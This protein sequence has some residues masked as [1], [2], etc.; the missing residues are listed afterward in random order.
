MFQ[1]EYISDALLFV[2]LDVQRRCVFLIF[3]F[4][5]CTL[6]QLVS[7]RGQNSGQFQ[8]GGAARQDQKPLLTCER[9]RNWCKN[10]DNCCRLLYNTHTIQAATRTT[11]HG[12]WSFWWFTRTKKIVS[13]GTNKH[14]NIYNIYVHT[15]LDVKLW[16]H[17][18]QCFFGLLVIYTTNFPL[19]EDLRI[20]KS[21]GIK[22]PQILRI[23]KS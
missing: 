19:S 2:D 5:K 1:Q 9:S 11:D 8:F 13:F 12:E 18:V 20:L 23:S 22:D 21:W 7:E 4:S 15:C 6:W 3:G 10:R 16:N 14:Y 17:L